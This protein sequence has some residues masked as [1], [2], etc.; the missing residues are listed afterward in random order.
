MSVSSISGTSS[1]FSSTTTSSTSASQEE[2]SYIDVLLEKIEEQQEAQA[3]QKEA[4]IKKEQMTQYRQSN[5]QD[6]V[7]LSKEAEAF[8]ISLSEKS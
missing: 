8:I 2:E 5:D 3:A 6:I 4:D 7:T 1:L